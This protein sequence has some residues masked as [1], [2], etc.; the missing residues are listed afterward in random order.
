MELSDPGIDFAKSC[1][2]I[3]GDVESNIFHGLSNEVASR[4]LRPRL[5]RE[6]R[7]GS[8]EY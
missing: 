6:D 4:G 8:I 5:P 2:E 7:V 1:V 3:G